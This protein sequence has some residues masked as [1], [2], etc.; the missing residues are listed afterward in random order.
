[1]LLWC[2]GGMSE[3]P[4]IAHRYFVT[5][6]TGFVGR[7]LLRELHQHHPEIAVKALERIS[8]N[9]PPLLEVGERFDPLYGEI[10]D[11]KERD[12][13][14]MDVVI[15]SA[16]IAHN[17]SKDATDH[18][19]VN[20][21]DTLELARK[22]AAA[23]VKRFVFL[24][25]V[26]V[27][28]QENADGKAFTPDSN[29]QPK[30]DY[31]KS[32]SQAEEGLR[33]IAEETGMEVV[34]VR[35]P[36]VYGPKPKANFQMLLNLAKLPAPAPMGALHDNQRSIVGI[37]NLLSAILLV[38]KHPDAAGK[39]FCPTDAVPLSPLQMY[40]HLAKETGGQAASFPVPKNVI[41]GAARFVGK[42]QTAH[43]LT[44]SLVMEDEGLKALGW[45]PPLTTE[46][47]FRKYFAK[48]MASESAVHR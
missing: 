1:M 21:D 48:E 33:K 25:S 32:K 44:K 9:R 18:Y 2:N 16:G 35:P 45:K 7:N 11:V 4:A 38:A 37:D 24:S 19:R 34:I 47:G 39:S 6:G 30:N 26:A 28:G 20:R 15:H 46:E 42:E 5:G 10:A 14:G 8:S 13:K 17:S 40:E 23:G 43:S 22:A 12:L 3:T 36:L 31:G 29:H 27:Y 41:E